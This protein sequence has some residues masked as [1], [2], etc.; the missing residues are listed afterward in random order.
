MPK[1]YRPVVLVILDGFGAPGNMAASTWSEA[2][3]PN[4]R[5][6]EK[7]YPFTSLQASGLA[8]GLPWGVSGNSEVGHLT[9]GAGRIINNYLPKISSAIKDGSFYENKVFL[10]A[11]EHIKTT[12]GA[13][14]LIGL[15]STGTVHAYSEHL[16]A[17]TDFAEKNS[18][19][20]FLHL[21]TDGKDAH[22]REGGEF[23]RKLEEILADKP[24]IK[25]ASI[26][27]RGFAMD[28]N[29]NWEKTKKTYELLT[30][31]AGNSFESASLYIQ[32]QY[33]KGLTD[34][35][36][37][38]GTALETEK[39]SRIKDGDAVIFFN[40]REDSV[41]QLTQAFM[42]DSFQFFPKKKL[43]NLFFA[44]MTE[45]DKRLPCFSG[46][47][48]GSCP[49]A[50]KS[51]EV[52]NSLAEIISNNNLSQLHTAE[53]E[54]YAHIT[55]F[56]NGG[57]E[58]SFPKEDRVLVPSPE[59]GHY[60]QTPE[61]SSDKIAANIVNN[62][63]KYDFIAANFANADMVGHTG[64]FEAT[65]KAIEKIDECL[66]K[67]TRV[68][69]ET[70]GVMIIT[71]DHGNAEEKRYN[72]GEDKTKHSLNPVPFFIIGKDFKKETPIGE[73]EVAE[74]YKNVS[75]TLADVAPTVLELLGLEKP[76]EMTGKSLT[77][78]IV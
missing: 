76:A 53:T 32:S 44:T 46:S 75:G 59:N 66:G 33:E 49:A 21:F 27:G 42:D 5:E 63:A 39:A 71:A 50:F 69:N 45:Y 10:G 26:I 62:L 56:L 70:D 17:L 24:Q 73:R 74:K 13:L 11:L 64:N 35:I 2:K 1:S 58:D 54:K 67:I 4:F 61:M 36:V 52:K 7:I 38:P 43:N 40:F 78:K 16:L 77:G 57:T 23:Y 22:K 29:G 8:V 68:I 34:D 48:G 31:N 19:P 14:H 9:I 6:F 30:E 25:I 65:I 28:R 15:F 72:S 55:Y 51:A 3:M 12:G 18:T 47:S 41:R 60:D 20:A 37:E